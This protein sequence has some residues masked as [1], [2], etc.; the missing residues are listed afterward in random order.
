M[1]KLSFLIFSC[2]FNKESS[3]GIAKQI[4]E[5]DSFF[6]F[7]KVSGNSAEKS[8][9]E[10]AVCTQTYPLLDKSVLVTTTSFGS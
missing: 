8:A 10:C 3:F 1:N 6:Q 4:I 2:S 7:L 9:K 5:F